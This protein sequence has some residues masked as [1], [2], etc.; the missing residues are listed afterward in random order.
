MYDHVGPTV[1]YTLNFIREM[2]DMYDMYDK[3]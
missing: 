1:G 3:V 2:Y